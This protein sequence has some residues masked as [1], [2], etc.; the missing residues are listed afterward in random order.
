MKKDPNPKTSRKSSTQMRRSNLKIIGIE[1]SED[2]QIKR[3]V[4]IFNK[5]IE[6]NFPNLNQQMPMSIQEAY[7]TP[8][9]FDQ[10]RN[11]SHNIII[12]TPNA[13][14]KGK[15]LKSVREK[16][17]VTYKGRATRITR[18][19]SRDC[20]SLA[21]VIQTRREQKC[22]PRLLYPTKLQLP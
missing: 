8:N 4:N 1:E 7:K 2:F 22:Q 15:L 21:D 18:D 14:N 6:E 5:A 20:E 12:K 9:S 16:G 10:K 11:S 3:P 19:L 17:E 13:Q